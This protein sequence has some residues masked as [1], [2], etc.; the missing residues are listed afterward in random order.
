MAQ[1]TF[2]ANPNKL[3]S[4]RILTEKSSEDD[5]GI[6]ETLRLPKRQLKYNDLNCLY[7][8]VARVGSEKNPLKAED[9]L[10]NVLMSS[11]DYMM[12]NA[13]DLRKQNPEHKK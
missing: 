12:L 10:L 7:F 6:R 9:S 1:M 8:C 5:L 2:A 3:Y 11:G 13:K 4:A